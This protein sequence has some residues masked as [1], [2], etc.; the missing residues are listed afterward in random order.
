MKFLSAIACSSVLGLIMAT[1][2]PVNAQSI[3]N[4]TP[5][6][7]ISIARQGQFKAQGIPSHSNFGNA[8]RSGKVDAQKLV[9]SAVAQN[10]LPETTL[11]DTNYLKS[12]DSHLKSGGC[13]SV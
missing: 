2:A 12:V 5:R 6:Q 11:Q 7:L 9:T 3:G 13:G 4:L 1:V 8:I 10:R